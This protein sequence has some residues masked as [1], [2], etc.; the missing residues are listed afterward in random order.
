VLL[1]LKKDSGGAVEEPSGHADSRTPTAPNGS[2]GALVTSGLTK[3]FGGLVAVNAVDFRAEAGQIH[4]LLGENG[5]GKSTFIKLVAGVLRADAGEIRLGDEILTYGTGQSRS[6]RVAAVFQEL[7]LVPDFTVAENIWIGMEPLDRL[8]GVSARGLRRRTLQLFDELRIEGISPDREV[9]LLSVAERH[10]VE[11]AKALSSSPQVIILDETTSALGPKE[12][13]WL[14]RQARTLADAGKT[15]L[16][17]SH[18]IA[19]MRDVADCITVLRGGENVG[20]RRRGEYA[21]DDLISLMLARRLGTFFPARDWQPTS[22]VAL[23]VRNLG[24]GYRLKGVDLDVFAGEILGVGGLQGQGQAQLFLTLYGAH[25]M[26]EGSLELM[27]EPV[28]IRS[29]RDALSAGLALVPED[30]RRQ[31]LLL[32]KPLRE[33]LTLAVLRQMSR[34]GVIDRRRESAAVS[35]AIARFQIVA[36]DSEQEVQWLSGGNQQKVLIA[37]LL[38]TKARILLL[39]DVTRGVDVGTK[40]QIFGFMRELAS[41]GYSILFY[42][43]D[44]SELAAMADRVAVMA[45]GRIVATL[46]GS[47]LTEEAILRAAV[48]ADVGS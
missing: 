30:R 47:G 22:E 17:I 45:E 13:D 15:V 21:E 37:K 29:V 14:L 38:M 26:R 20:T 6:R 16:F 28:R 40:P 25:P 10:L 3:S 4:G 36:R 48:Q 44:A 24:D 39:F 42:S 33:N 11:T 41:S 27:G 19:E 31:G 2:S 46:D 43:T 9:R 8:G 12:T 34:F 5:A 1:L 18:R 32:T 23:R 35:E 7:S